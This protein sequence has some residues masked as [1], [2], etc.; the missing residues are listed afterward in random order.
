MTQLDW[1]G[2]MRAGL[3]GLGL[4]PAEFWQ[5]T[6]AELMLMLGR[7]GSEAPLNRSRLDELARAFP[8]LEGGESHE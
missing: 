3:R 2:L 8:D 1:P 5:L 7:D 6:P 4:K